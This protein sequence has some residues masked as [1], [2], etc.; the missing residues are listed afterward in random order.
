MIYWKYKFQFG[1]T[2]EERFRYMQDLEYRIK[3][4]SYPYYLFLNLLKWVFGLAFIPVYIVTYAIHIICSLISLL[5]EQ[6]TEVIYD[7]LY[8]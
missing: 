6:I 4:I 2:T 1:K 3:S 5:F 8:K 7:I